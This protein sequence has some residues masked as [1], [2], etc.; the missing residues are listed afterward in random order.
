MTVSVLMHFWRNQPGNKDFFQAK[1]QQTKGINH[2]DGI[3]L[4]RIAHGIA[5]VNKRSRQG[6]TNGK[7][8]KR[9]LPNGVFTKGADFFAAVKTNQ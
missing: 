4:S 2:A 7:A 1:P 8:T 5:T 9:S 6:G 3:D